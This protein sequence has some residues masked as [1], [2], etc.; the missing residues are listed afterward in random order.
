MVSIWMGA[1]P[2]PLP[3]LSLTLATVQMG[4]RAY[5]V[6]MALMAPLVQTD[7][8]E[9]PTGDVVLEEVLVAAGVLRE[10]MPAVMEE[11]AGQ[12]EQAIVFARVQHPTGRL[13]KMEEVPEEEMAEVEVPVIVRR[14]AFL[15][16][17]TQARQM[18]V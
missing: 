12:E 2:I 9:M 4:F 11:M 3:V 16:V 6:L 1:H 13:A 10:V 8:R 14:F 7:S 5:L 17:V 18:Q 15:Q